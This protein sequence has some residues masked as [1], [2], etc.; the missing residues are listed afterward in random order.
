MSE[1]QKT[2]PFQSIKRNYNYKT[3]YGVLGQKKYAGVFMEE[4]LTELQGQRGIEA[5]K[6]MAENDD[7]IGAMLFAIEML[8]R[9]APWDV[10]P[11]GEKEEDEKAANFVKSCL[12]DMQQSWQDTLSE[13]LSFL[14]YGWSY[15]EICYKRR[16]GKNKKQSLSSKYDD[17]LIGWKK[18]PIRSQDTLWRWEYDEEDEL[19]GM[20]QM[21]PPDYQIRTI[22]LE[23]AIHFVTKSKK[24]NPEGRSI[25]RNAYRQYY[26]KKRFQEIEGIGVERDLAGL[27]FI[28]P[29]EG[30]D[31]WDAGDP[32][33]VRALANC[34]SLVKNIRRDAKEGVV[35]PY[36]WT[37]QLLNGGSRRQFEV[38]KIIER[39]DNRI[40]MTAMADFVLLGHQQTGSFALSSDKTT[41][42][43]V[44]LGTYLNIICDAFNTQ[45]IPRLIDLNA[46]HFKGITQYPKLVHGD[47]EQVNMNEF[48]SFIEKMTGIGVLKPDE[49]LERHVR[50]VGNLP[51]AM[52]IQED[53]PTSEMT[54][55]N[56]G[57]K[58]I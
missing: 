3:E 4:F 19:A 23:K 29:P 45:A 39:C 16:M 50:K 32:E 12:D 21:A 24:A 30:A 17:G 2:S 47:V 46:A 52:D 37:F 41:L 42:F 22:P 33:M 20:S 14:V 11:Q 31:I 36:G 54:A 18:L 7:I 6:E 26:F 5:Y 8:I 28:Q 44:A 13:I 34:E 48:A 49:N 35:L 27:P 10:E 43:S 40:A 57:G 15:H 56:K 1:K 53:I 51:E 9:Q 38:G 58:S 55:P 25:L